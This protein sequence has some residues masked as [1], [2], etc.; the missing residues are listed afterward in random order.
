MSEAPV[1]YDVSDGIAT[2]TLNRPE[3]LNAWTAQLGSDYWDALDQASGDGA[4]RG[5][6][7]TGAGRG[8][9]AGADMDLLQGIQ[10]GDKTKPVRA[11]HQSYALSVPKPIVAA[12]N[13]AC[14]GLGMVLATMADVRIAS[15][16]AKFTT[17]FSRRGL[18]AEHGIGWVLPKLVG[19]SKALDML[20]TGRVFMAD[21]AAAMGFVNQVVEPDELT[22]ATR[23][24]LAD[25]VANVSPASMAV[26]KKQ[27]WSGL[28]QSMSESNEQ[29]DAAMAHSLRQADFK[30]GVASFLEKRP[31]AFQDL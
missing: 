11:E 20:M 30:E 2:I 24:Y 27:V 28:E 12:V 8:F 22:N 10:D 3:R 18:I 1:L 15:S 5:I 21:E 13:G 25:I 26:M 7:V 23:A 9:C 6:I 4:V 16:T 29:A 17:A 31:P 19:P 14:A